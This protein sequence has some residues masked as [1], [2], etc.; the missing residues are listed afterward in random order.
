MAAAGWR[1]VGEDLATAA[2]HERGDG[3]GLSGH[4]GDSVT[5]MAVPDS[6]IV[7]V[8][9]RAAR[10]KVERQHPPSPGAGVKH[11]HRAR[12][13][14]S[15]SGQ[16]PGMPGR[17]STATITRDPDVRRSGE[18]RRHTA[19]RHTGTVRFGGGREPRVTRRKC[20]CVT[21]RV[22]AGQC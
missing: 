6:T 19:P 2:G 3:L 9:G 8:P 4:R 17:V 5:F 14:W 22:A 10:I 13:P 1:G 18:R 16:L 15:L 20:F 11:G 21:R 12:L 7:N